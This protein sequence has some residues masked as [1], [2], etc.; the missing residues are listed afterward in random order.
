MNYHPFCVAF[1]TTTLLAIIWSAGLS[2]Q[3]TIKPYNPAISGD[4]TGNL[5]VPHSIRDTPVLA[6]NLR[7]IS[8]RNG[9]V[10]FR[11]CAL[12]IGGGQLF[13]K[14]RLENE[15]SIDYTI[16]YLRCC[17]KDRKKARRTASQEITLTPIYTQGL[18][19]E[20]K[21]HDQ[22]DGLLVF[23]K[24]T[25]PDEKYIWIELQEKQGSRVLGCKLSGKKIL[26]AQALPH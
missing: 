14:I 7:R 20:I 3:T 25:I 6:N 21:S 15:S 19:T 18:N 17:I 5:I 12:Y 13:M 1:S 23:P 9:L 8:S 22:N 24:F 16:A 11:L 4:K 2:A 26:R 10:T